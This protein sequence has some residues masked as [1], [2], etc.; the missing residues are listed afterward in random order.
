MALCYL[1][2]LKRGVSDTHALDFA[3]AAIE[4]L[5]YHTQIAKNREKEANAQILR[6]LKYVPHC[7]TQTVR[8][9]QTLEDPE[10]IDWLVFTEIEFEIM[11]L[12][13]DFCF[14]FQSEEDRILFK[15][16]WL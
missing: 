15:L 1:G 9:E 5:R 13:R 10:F 8:F 6:L 4:H 11:C 3:T 12:D 7:R 2:K 14:L 16:R